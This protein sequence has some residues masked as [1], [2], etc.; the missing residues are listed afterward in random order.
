M[1]VKLA[2]NAVSTIAASITAAAT[3]L[4]VQGADAGK[5]PPLDEGDWHPATII[6]PAGNMEIVRVTAR[7]GAVM[8]IAR[9]QEGTTARAFAAGSRIDVRMTAGA[10]LLGKVDTEAF[11]A[12]NDAFELLRANF[13][14][15]VDDAP[16]EL[17][18]LVEIATLL[19]AKANKSGDKFTGAIDLDGNPLLNA[20]KGVPNY[21]KGLITSKTAAYTISVAA[22]EIKGNGKFV[23][24][25]VAFSKR[26]DAVWAAGSGNGGRLDAAAIAANKTYHLQALR[27]DSD[28]SFDWGYSLAPIPATVPAGYTWVGR[29][30]WCYTN[31]TPNAIV[32]YTQEGSKKYITDT[33]WFTSS[34][35]LPPALYTLPATCPVPSGIPVNVELQMDVTASPGT[36]ITAVVYDGLSPSNNSPAVRASV[37][38]TSANAVASAAGKAKSNT[39]RQ[40]WAVTAGFGSGTINVYAGASEDFTLNRIY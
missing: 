33:L 13:D 4:S 9:A 15:L 10:F 28:G 29:F 31:A 16:P 36:S 7:V 17:N 37:S 38:A 26:L 20:G 6:D 34:A 21:L 40:L 23:E 30:D 35:N 1:V 18:T 8:T 3:S 27:K 19:L 24:N 39:S 5:F 32:D 25:T 12:L 11:Q 22:G 2:N 14:N